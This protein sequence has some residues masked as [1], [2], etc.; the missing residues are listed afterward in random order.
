MAAAVMAT[1]SGR[2]QFQPTVDA[3]RWV[4]IYPAYLNVNYSFAQVRA[5][6]GRQ[7]RRAAGLGG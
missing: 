4:V 3:A 5:A 1:S 2:P 7:R 6:G